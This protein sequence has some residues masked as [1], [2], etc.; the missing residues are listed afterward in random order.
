MATSVFQIEC[1]RYFTDFFFFLKTCVYNRLA[2]LCNY[3][4]FFFCFLQFEFE[5]FI[6]CNY[7]S[8]VRN[9]D[10]LLLLYF[11]FQ[12]FIILNKLSYLFILKGI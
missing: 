8:C 6:T 10:L 2:D 9:K 5:Y 12:Y 11:K 3:V 7:V 4:V 1:S